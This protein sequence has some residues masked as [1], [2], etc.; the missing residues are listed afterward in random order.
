M[1]Q[2]N[3]NF[4]SVRKNTNLTPAGTI[5]KAKTIYRWRQDLSGAGKNKWTAE[6]SA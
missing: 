3:L 1:F 5:L 4:V 2:V 6:V